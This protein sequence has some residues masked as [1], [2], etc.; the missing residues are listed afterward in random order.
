[1]VAQLSNSHETAKFKTRYEQARRFIAPMLTQGLP[2]PGKMRALEVGCG[3]GPKAC[4]LA[5]MFKEYIGIDLDR[6]SISIGRRNA[7]A[8]G[9][10]V[11]LR[12]ME[13]AD[14]P[15]LLSTESFDI[16]ILYAILEHLTIDERL[17]TLAMC[18]NALPS[19]GYLLIGEAPNRIS[20]IDYHS[21][22]I[23]YFHLMPPE[24]AQR[25]I[26]RSSH[27]NW[28]KGVRSE[29]T[30]ELGLYR[31]GQ[32][33]GFEEFDLAI[34]PVEQIGRLIQFDGW[35][36][37]MM[38]LYPLRWFELRNLEDF[39]SFATQGTTKAPYPSMFARYW[40]EALLSKTP[41]P[42]PLVNVRA[43]RAVGDSVDRTST[44]PLGGPVI[45]VGPN[46]H[47]TFTLGSSGQQVQVG[48]TNASRG[49]FRVTCDGYILHEATVESVKGAN[50]GLWAPQSWITVP[51]NGQDQ[52]RVEADKD[53]WL[54]LLT[55]L[56]R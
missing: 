31:Y 32:H 10:T 29:R 23:P 55:P 20:P 46:R 1:M 53:S 30:I 43:L 39:A 36:D 22:K 14:L 13:A 47:A 6:K 50:L 33:V 38:N 41:P 48:L 25:F 11:D 26:D 28:I 8:L 45:A 49:S 16:I 15:Q 7:D 34:E 12:L 2:N 37:G 19:D 35:S 42:K 51:V 56:A 27:K 24:L 9:L 52:I 54:G 17:S 21:S 5:P 44:D 3:E 18:W 4:A 40:I